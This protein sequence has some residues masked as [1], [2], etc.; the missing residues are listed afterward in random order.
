M[1]SFLLFKMHSRQKLSIYSILTEHHVKVYFGSHKISEKCKKW[2]V[3]LQTKLW[4]THVFL[5]DLLESRWA[6]WVL[7]LGEVGHSTSP[8]ILVEI[9]AFFQRHQKS[10]IVFLPWT[11]TTNAFSVILKNSNAVLRYD[12]MVSFIQRN[13]F[14][15]DSLDGLEPAVMDNTAYLLS[16]GIYLIRGMA[17]SYQHKHRGW[18]NFTA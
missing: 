7:I 15:C 10:F 18:A 2:Q 9:R 12:N 11:E 5:D 1:L 8:E 3:L 6:C 16:E 14:G 4:Y 17:V 13:S